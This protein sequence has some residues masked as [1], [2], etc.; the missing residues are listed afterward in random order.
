MKK[1]LK[2]ATK[3]HYNQQN[4]SAAQL[5]SLNAILST[6]ENNSERNIDSQL[7]TIKHSKKQ[8]RWLAIAATFLL[9][10]AVTFYMQIENS[11]YG[12]Q[13]AQEVVANH[14]RL[15]PLEVKS[16]SFAIV[17]SYF[18]ELDFNPV[19][20]A[21]TEL[22]GMTMLGGRYC[23]IKSEIAAQLRYQDKQGNMLTL[24]QVGFDAE[25]F[26]DIPAKESGEKPTTYNV[27]GFNVTLWTENGLLMALVQPL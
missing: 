27:K 19:Q 23:S 21:A 15:R 18:T 7:F 16:D 2:Q 3:D 22:S 5:G 8:S 10:I 17:S 14:V 24:Y 13:L 26:G 11:T 20:S 12:V 4:L 1:S 9:G 6:S 25:K